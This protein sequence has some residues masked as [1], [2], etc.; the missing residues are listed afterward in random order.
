[1]TANTIHIG[2]SGEEAEKELQSFYNWLRDDED[3]RQHAQVALRWSPPKESEMGTALEA[4]ELVLSNSFEVA[5]LTLAYLAWRYTRREKPK[6]TFK[7]GDL[8]I[9]VDGDDE[10]TVKKIIRSFKE[11]SE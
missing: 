10:E 7:H 9:T 1:M 6:V 2:M 4:I 5:N 3:I 8:E 11:D